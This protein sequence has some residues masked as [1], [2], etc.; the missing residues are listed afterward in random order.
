MLTLIQRQQGFSASCCFL[1]HTPAGLSDPHT[2][3]PSHTHIQTYADEH[4]MNYKYSGQDWRYVQHNVRR[5]HNTHCAH[6]NP[7]TELSVSTF[8]WGKKNN[9]KKLH[10]CS[11]DA[12][13][14]GRLVHVCALWS[15]DSSAPIAV[16]LSVLS[17]H[18][19]D[20]LAAA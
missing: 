8:L 10:I 3:F 1:P 20:V 12:V 14:L 7:A 18:S 17:Q 5:G 4:M 6:F 19:L 15:P 16:F 9:K 2:S 13:H 11:S